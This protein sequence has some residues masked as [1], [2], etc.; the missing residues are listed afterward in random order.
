MY[1]KIYFALDLDPYFK[2]F[3]TYTGRSHCYLHGLLS[4]LHWIYV[5]YSYIEN[6]TCKIFVYSGNRNIAV[7]IIIIVFCELL[8][9]VFKIFFC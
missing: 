9:H 7:I 4:H 5:T 1:I 6:N 3:Q 2:A 8:S